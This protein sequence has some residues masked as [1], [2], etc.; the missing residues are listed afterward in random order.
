MAVTVALVLFPI[1]L[2]RSLSDEVV[3]ARLGALW[4]IA[5]TAALLMALALGLLVNALSGLCSALVYLKARELGGEALVDVGAELR[6]AG[7]AGPRASVLSAG[8]WRE[9]L[10]GLVFVAIDFRLAFVDLVP[11]AIGYIL[12]AVGLRRLA[13]EHR[14][15]RH[16]RV[17]AAI[18][19]VLSLV[20]LVKSRMT[21]ADASANVTGDPTYLLPK[22]VGDA[23]LAGATTDP[24]AINEGRSHN[25]EGKRIGAPA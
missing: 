7:A 10:W 19:I 13:P 16:A 1:D 20:G 5:A 6:S 18:M 17:V 2:A 14:A 11:D 9:V 15:F 21:F 12:I 24:A 23:E 4:I 22:R 25:P 3:V 8:A